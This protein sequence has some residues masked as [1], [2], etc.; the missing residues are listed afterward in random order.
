[1]EALAGG[2]QTAFPVW[3]DQRNLEYIRVA[4]RLN[5]RQA[6]W[7]LFFARFQFTISYRPGSK[8]VKADA[9]SRLYD[10]E[11]R[12]GEEI[13]IIAPVV[14]DVN[15]DIRKALHTEP[16]PAQCPENR[17]YVPTGG[18]NRLLSWALCRVMLG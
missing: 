12:Q 16:A 2:V 3:T 14:W 7:A 1:M 18:R 4:K 17:A 13:P 5:T 6:R 11:E 9:L 10:V 8:N 15:A